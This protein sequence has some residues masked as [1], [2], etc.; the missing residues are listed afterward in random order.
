MRPSETLSIYRVPGW[1]PRFSR[2]HSRCVLQVSLPVGSISARAARDSPQTRLRLFFFF[3]L[4]KAAAFSAEPP[5]T[6]SR[7]AE[8]HRT[9]PRTLSSA[10]QTAESTLA[11]ACDVPH[12]YSCL[13]VVMTWSLVFFSLWPMKLQ[14]RTCGCG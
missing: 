7:G 13:C 8:F 6:S 3:N 5:P 2:L 14:E 9:G 12:L 4:T 1:K 10:W 11:G